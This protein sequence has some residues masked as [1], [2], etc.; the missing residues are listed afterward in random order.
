[1]KVE[2]F[3]ASCGGSEDLDWTSVG[4]PPWVRLPNDFTLHLSDCHAGLGPYKSLVEDA[5]IPLVHGTHITKEVMNA[6]L[7]VWNSDLDREESGR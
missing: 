5:G 4:F 1:M 3:Q 6:A 7:K 2:L